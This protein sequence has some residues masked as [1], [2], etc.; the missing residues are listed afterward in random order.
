MEEGQKQ[1]GTVT[2]P[3][4]EYKAEEPTT[5]TSPQATQARSEGVAWTASEYV[6]HQKTAGWYMLLA[7]GAIVGAALV[8]A[9]TKDKI[10]VVMIVIVAIIFGVFAARQPRVLQY[11]LDESG[12]EIGGKFYPYAMFKSFAVIQEGGI[13]SIS[14]M[15]LKR[16]MP[17]LS[18]YFAPDDA[19]KIVDTLGIY[20]PHED[21]QADPI[22]RLMRRLRF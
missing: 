8:Y 7:L 6:A 4:W 17:I 14:L 20:L 2:G 10:S 22:D 21:R 1:S 15:P 13:E 12:L 19:D 9:L 18:I 5:P 11:R 16:F 3:Q